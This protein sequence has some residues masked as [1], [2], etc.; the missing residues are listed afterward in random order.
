[1][2]IDVSAGSKNK[3]GEARGHFSVVE[4]G[5]HSRHCV[6]TKHIEWGQNKAYS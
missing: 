2:S 6:S 5:G 1:M 3:I 4:T